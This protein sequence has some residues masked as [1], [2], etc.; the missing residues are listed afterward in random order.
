[1]P[2]HYFIGLGG[3]GGNVLKA[4]RKGMHIRQNEIKACGADLRYDFLYVDS[5][6]EEL[7]GMEKSWR[8]LGQPVHLS[9]PQKLLIRNGNLKAVLEDLGKY[10]AIKPW[11]GEERE[12]RSL[13]AG[14]SGTPGAQQRRRFGRF[15]FANNVVD[16]FVPTIQERMKLMITD[17]AKGECT[18]HI[19]ATLG[20]G[21][22]SGTLVDAAVQLRK[23]FP[24][25]SD[26]KICVYVLVT[27][28]GGD[29]SDVGHFYPNQYAALKDINAL[30]LGRL[31][32]HDLGHPRG[33]YFDLSKHDQVIHNCVLLSN[34]NDVNSRLS[35]D[36][37]ERMLG[38]W[39]LQTVLARASQSLD[40]QF[41]KALTNEDFAPA[42]PGEPTLNTE[43][44][45]RF[46]SVG[47]FR[48]SVPEQQIREYF[49]SSAAISVVDQMTWNNWSEGRSF[50]NSESATTARN[51]IAANPIGNFGISID[52][53]T[54]NGSGGLP[55]FL[56]E[57]ANKLRKGVM[58]QAELAPNP[59][60]TL[61]DGAERFFKHEFRDTGV[62]AYFQAMRNTAD[63]T[64][65]DLVGGVERKLREG[66]ES[67]QIGMHDC[68]TILDMLDA[69]LSIIMDRIN[70]ETPEMRNRSKQADAVLSQR[71]AEWNKIGFLSSLFG[72][73]KKLLNAHLETLVSKN[74]LDTLCAAFD[75]CSSVLAK[76]RT[77]LTSLRTSCSQ[78][79][80]MLDKLRESLVQE[81]TTLDS[82]MK[83]SDFLGYTEINRDELEA[84]RKRIVSDKITMDQIAASCR[85]LGA[86]DIADFYE[87]Q[88][89]GFERISVRV[90]SES[91]QATTQKANDIARDTRSGLPA[92]I[93]K[94]LLERL[95]QRFGQ[96]EETLRTEVKK[97]VD[98]AIGA[99]KL[100]AA[101]P[102][103]AGL[104]GQEIPS[105]PKKVILVQLPNIPESAAPHERQQF[106]EFV[107]SL[108]LAIGNAISGEIPVIFGESTNSSE[109]T[110]ISQTYL[111]PA[112]FAEA[113][114]GLKEKFDEKT[115]GGS[116]VAKA[117]RYFCHLSSDWQ[118]TPD[119]F[120]EHGAALRKSAAAY[121]KIAAHL[122]ILE[123]GDD[124]K[125]YLRRIDENGV[126]KA[127]EAAPSKEILLTSSDVE[128][129][130]F[131]AFVLTE[132]AKRPR[133][134]LDEVVLAEKN[135]LNAK[136]VECENNST[137]PRY[138]AHQT[139]FEE[140]VNALKGISSPNL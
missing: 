101:A 26:Y 57:W 69:D 19:F 86:E 56:V 72:K 38:E 133:K 87:L 5:N 2:N 18:F 131:R 63:R 91:E 47:I 44:S 84:Y 116:D 7:D 92:I 54:A 106:T 78:I 29:A 102:S 70:A 100:D 60:A 8:V 31:R 27:S 65:K 37:Q 6:K 39:V 121:F 135:S 75:Y 88:L 114:R 71:R 107:N 10:P 126:V 95:Y 46:S 12:I 109:M 119:L 55:T 129:A 64:A 23:H 85:N 130:E 83:N 58:V 40:A 104:A 68:R 112:R 52:S 80:G 136:L 110:V 82:A 1:M 48:W 15:L 25:T 132:L 113:I 74:H 67:G 140:I 21:T 62:V 49:A 45:F 51:F 9:T 123:L 24:K 124:L 36:D 125:V 120:P 99:L 139:E 73:K 50:T 76:V 89:K 90:E 127:E 115:R 61:E 32:I 96:S 122:R 97:F 66:W 79:H 77:E 33:D 22:G 28:D 53:I 3:T 16:K 35:K 42:L 14:E 41:T 134:E 94:N 117:N 11:L 137:H 4:L 17:G 34:W 93:G 108:K 118:G 59:L 13:I 111:M 105:M 128:L 138:R 30:M 81:V 98:S 20:G 43:R 103:P